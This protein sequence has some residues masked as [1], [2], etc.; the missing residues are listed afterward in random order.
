MSMTHKHG[1]RLYLGDAATGS[2]AAYRRAPMA[3]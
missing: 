3:S 1:K 2:S